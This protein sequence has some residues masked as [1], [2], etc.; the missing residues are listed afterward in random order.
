MCVCVCVRVR[1]CVKVFMCMCRVSV[2]FVRLVS[3]HVC[4]MNVD[5]NMHVSRTRGEVSKGSVK[6]FQICF[7]TYP[8]ALPIVR[9]EPLSIARHAFW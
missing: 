6:K 5:P 2:M 7:H 1:V 9:D 3:K 4:E 8:R